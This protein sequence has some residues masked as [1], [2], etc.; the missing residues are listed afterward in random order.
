MK[1]RL[2][3]QAIAVIAIVSSLSAQAHDPKEHMKDAEKPDCA[4]MKNMDHS[5]MD[6]D[7]PVMKAMMEKCM[8]A[9]HEKNESQEDDKKENNH[10]Q[11]DM[12]EESS[13][14]NH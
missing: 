10:Q 9:T 6:H 11:K 3:P 14:H 8:P 7:D 13:E 5:K 12:H 1:I 2:I 4:A